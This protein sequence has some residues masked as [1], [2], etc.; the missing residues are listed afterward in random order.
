MPRGNLMFCNWV[1]DDC[2]GPTC[3]YASCVKQRLLANGV[4]GAALRRKTVDEDLEQTATGIRVKGKLY[5][6]LR[7]KEIY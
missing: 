7:E 4:C 6:R 5:Q 1:E 2:E 3:N